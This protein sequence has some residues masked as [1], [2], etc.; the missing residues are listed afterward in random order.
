MADVVKKNLEN[1]GYINAFRV[2]PADFKNMKLTLIENVDRESALFKSGRMYIEDVSLLDYIG[3]LVGSRGAKVGYCIE[4][5]LLE[6]G[7]ER[8]YMELCVS[9]EDDRKSVKAVI[10]VVL[11]ELE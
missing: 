4:K 11:R 7:G 9:D 5:Y 3:H 8:I 6:R 10:E 2:G 1:G